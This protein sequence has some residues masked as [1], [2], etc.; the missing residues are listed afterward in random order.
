MQ[1]IALAIAVLAAAAFAPHAAR[2][3]SA[4][5]TLDCSLASNFCAVS[6][7]SPSSPTPLKIWWSFDTSGTDAIFPRDCAHQETCSFWCPR[8]EGAIAAS[9]QVRDAANVLI[10]SASAPAVCTQQDI[11]LP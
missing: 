10:G 3:Q 5:V 6:V 9:V 1:R 7:D 8:Y 2:A 11:V 4:P